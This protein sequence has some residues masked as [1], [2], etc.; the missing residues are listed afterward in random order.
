[1]QEKSEAVRDSE[2]R[3]AVH[4]DDDKEQPTSE[5][6]IKLTVT[7]A[8]KYIDAIKARSAQKRPD[9][10]N[11]FLD[12]MEDFKSHVINTRRSFIKP[13]RRAKRFGTRI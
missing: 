6:P 13:I 8:L 5:E 10:Y 1:M 2:Q 4:D 7:D 3:E 12:T 11:D 9:V